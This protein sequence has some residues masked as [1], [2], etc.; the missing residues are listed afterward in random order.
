MYRMF[1]LKLSSHAGA[2]TE[3]SD[4]SS[5]CGGLVGDLLAGFWT[6][7]ALLPHILHHTR[8]LLQ[9]HTPTKFQIHRI[10]QI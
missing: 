3:R 8:I 4:L 6:A 5:E 7:N 9:I 10:K 1:T 2:K